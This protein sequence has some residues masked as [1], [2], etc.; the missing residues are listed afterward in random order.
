MF[1]KELKDFQRSMSFSNMVSSCIIIIFFPLLFL[2][3]NPLSRPRFRLYRHVW[4]WQ[5]VKLWCVLHGTTMCMYS[6]RGYFGLTFRQTLMSSH[7]PTCFSSLSYFYSIPYGRR[8][9][10]LMGHDDAV[11][12]MCWFDERLFTASWDSTVKVKVPCRS[13]SSCICFSGIAVVW[14]RGES[15]RWFFFILQVWQC[16]SASTSSHRRSQF[17]LLAELEHDSGVSAEVE[18]LWLFM[19]Q[20]VELWYYQRGKHLVYCV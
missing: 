2:C 12:E 6:T 13:W 19:L 3:S 10:T 5:M 14:L 16:P 9:E 7:W 8:Q 11:S 4:C 15:L 20:K 1:S 17:E 18:V